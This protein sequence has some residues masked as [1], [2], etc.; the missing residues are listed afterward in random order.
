MK[1]VFD[2]DGTLCFNGQPVSGKILSSLAKAMEAGIEI[3]FASARP[4]RDM[5]PVINE[6]FHHCTMIGGNG[7][8]LAK[9]GKIIERRSFSAHEIQNIKELIHR[10]HAAYLID[11]DWDYAYT[12][13]E[14]HP[15]LR[16]VDPAGLAKQ[17]PLESL[18]E[19]VKVLILSSKQMDELAEELAKLNVYVHIHRNEQV[20][21]ISPNGI[22]KWS[23]LQSLGVEERSYVAFG[24]DANDISMFEHALHTVMIGDHEQLAPYAKETIR[25]SGDVE[26]A[27][28]AKI[29]ELAERIGSNLP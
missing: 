7:S 2:L 4:I 16:N 15:I 23:A 13:P 28:A 29:L 17:V 21:D 3:I 9:G 19:I 20:L 10:Y 1:F 6:A 24:N 11:G 27:I 5:L 14:S 12:G 26:Q 8:L 22:H 18:Q 25:L